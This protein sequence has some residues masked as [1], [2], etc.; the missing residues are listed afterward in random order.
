[1]HKTTATTVTCLTALALA[2]SALPAAA[3]VATATTATAPDGS[4]AARP[5]AAVTPV[6]PRPTG[7]FPIGVVD[8][9]LIDRSRPDPWNPPQ[10]DRELMVSVVYPAGDVAG[11]ERAPLMTPGVRDGFNALA[12]PGNY[13]V[14]AGTTI[15]WAAIKTY[16]HEDAPAAPGRHPVVLYSPGVG[17]VRSWDSVL[18]DQLASE[19]YVMVTIDP[20]YEAAAVQFPADAAHPDGRVVT[21]NL[22]D[23]YAKAEQ[24]GTVTQLLRQVLNTR[25]ADTKFVLDELGELAAG[26]DPDAEHRSLPAGLGHELDMRDVG[27]FGQSAGGFTALETMYEDP[28]LKAGIDMDGTLEFNAGDPT[29]TNFSP[30]AEHGLAKPFLLLGSQ[31]GDACTAATDP[32]CAAVLQHSTGWHRAL[33]LPGTVHGSFTDAEAI[34]PQLSGVLPAGVIAGDVGDAHPDE[35]LAE[36]ET[37]IS[38]FFH[39]EL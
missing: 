15:D 14:P 30:V 29:D 37:L 11:R 6:L 23:W 36:E 19:G 39:R 1:M 7:R 33:T 24:D 25:V 22:L 18:V 12:A 27:M 38:G 3:A 16:E 35:V 31:T 28:R 9:H 21:S 10:A 4:G 5:A 13:G 20:T 17:D 26:G 32:S 34:F 2:A 8:L